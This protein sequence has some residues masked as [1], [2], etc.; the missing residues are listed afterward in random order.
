MSGIFLTV[1]DPVHRHQSHVLRPTRAGY[2]HL[3][4][5]YTGKEVTV[6]SLKDVAA[7]VLSTWAFRT[8][9]LV[10]AVPSSFEDRPGHTRH[11]VILTIDKMAEIEETRTLFLR[12]IFENHASFTMRVPHVTHG[13]YETREEAEK[14]AQDL[15]RQHLPCA[16]KVIG[17]TID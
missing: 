5:A 1:W 2:P 4:V 6:E 13:S 10:L 16:V 7:H 15:N 12:S 8:I 14:V 9:T 17:V 11:D 3:T